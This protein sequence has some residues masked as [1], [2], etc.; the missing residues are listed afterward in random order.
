MQLYN[1]IL[2]NNLYFIF[3]LLGFFC[4]AIILLRE[5]LQK[6][7]VRII[8]LF[9]CLAFGLILEIG[10][11]YLAHTYSYSSSFLFQIYN[12]PIAIGFGWAVIIY[13]AMLLSDQY[14]IPWRI[15]P[16]MDALTALILDLSMDIVAIRL[17]FW[18]WSIPFDQE[19]YG[20]PFENLIGWIFVVFTFSY[21]MRF[22]RTLNWDRVRTKILI[23]LSPFISYALLFLELAI[24]S[25]I[26]ILP[27]Q[28]N[29]WTALLKFNYVPDLMLLYNPQVQLWKAIVLVVVLT[30]MVDIVI[31]TLAKQNRTYL[32]QFDLLSFLVLSLMHGFFFMAI[33]AAGIYKEM[34]ILVVI[35]INVFLVHCLIHFLPYLINPKTIYLF[36]ETKKVINKRGRKIK[37]MIKESFK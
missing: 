4:F 5:I 3:E 36:K 6:N 37:G 34:P 29:N 28:I 30:L 11:T 15:R 23:L 13:C 35:G 10:N 31:R 32:Y 21:L 18:K 14:N 17:G 25:I 24:F 27:Y 2:G 26:V 19:W 16:I 1:I 12:V 8:E 9:S 22:I 7:K 20:V 33:F